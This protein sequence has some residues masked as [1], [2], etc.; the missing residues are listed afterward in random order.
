MIEHKIKSLC[1]DSGFDLVGISS[2]HINK[3]DQQNIQEWIDSKLYAEMEWFPSRQNIRIHFENLGFKVNSVIVLGSIYFYKKND[4]FVKKS[5][6]KISRYALGNDYHTVL[7]KKI[8]SVID[9][10]R[11][12]FPENHFRI[13]IDSLPVAEKVLAKQA[14]LGWQGKNTNIINDKK[15]SYFFL[16]V[17]LTDLI[18][19]TDSPAIDR[20]GKCMACIDACPTNALFEPYKLDA[21]K[22]ISYQ[23]IENKSN[24]IPEEINTS[25]YIFGCDICQ[26]VCPWNHKVASKKN[27]ESKEIEFLITT[28][29]ENTNFE[30]IQKKEFEALK[31]KSSLARIDYKSFLRNINKSKE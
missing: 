18:L 11:I 17:I 20:C 8:E 23:T 10:L 4:E 5:K 14:G 25:S 9:I 19:E 15:G 31:K 26:E 2:A 3:Q 30:T 13:G 24:F 22:C 7:R 27:V 6:Y 16:A 12:Q 21:G 1:L 29:M 28:E